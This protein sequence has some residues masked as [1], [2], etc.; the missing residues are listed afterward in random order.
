MCPLGPTPYGNFTLVPRSIW[1]QNWRSVA[2]HDSTCRPIRDSAVHDRLPP[3]TPLRLALRSVACSSALAIACPLVARADDCA[4]LEERASL[5]RLS[6]TRITSVQV[7]TEGPSLPGL[8]QRAAGLHPVSR[9]ETIQRQLLF[10]AGDTVDTILVGETMR[11]LRAQRLFSDAVLTAQYCDAGSNTSAGTALVVRTRDAWTLRPTARLRSSSSLSVGIEERNLLG[12]GRTLAVTTELSTRG[13]GAGVTFIDPWLF[14]RD[15]SGTFRAAKLAGAHVFRAG[16]R[17]HEYS[18]F[19]SWRAEGNFARNSYGDTIA[20]ERSLHTVAAMLLVGRRIGAPSSS[21]VTLLLAGAEFDSASA[22]SP[23]RRMRRDSAAVMP[24]VRSFLGLDLGLMRRTALYDTASWIV[25]GRGFL[26]VPLGWEGEAV[27]GSGYERDARSPA[28]KL[29]TWLGRIW[30]PQRGSIFTLDAW[31]SGYAGRGVDANDIAR[32]SA[33]WYD[34]AWGGMW[35]ARF[36]A[37]RMFEVDPDR[38]SLSLMMLTDY[39][40]PVVRPFA[41]RAGRTVA[42]S[43]ERSAHLFQVGAASVFD[44]GAFAGASYR[45]GVDGARDRQLR[46]GVVGARFRLLSANGAVSSVRLDVGYP[47][48]LNRSLRRKP[49]A[50]LTFGNLFDVVRQRDGRRQF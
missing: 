40:A 1:R 20:T 2:A 45:W 3:P 44:A 31:L 32:L 47:V 41:L 17:N 35:G 5:A 23:T 24:H 8:A 13:N 27:V 48:M 6:G 49:F 30:L 29:D 42:G 19:D 37:E 9:P 16:L 43:I 22:I 46:A 12:T 14:G 28:F 10:A 33:G 11:R 36:T 18:V 34:Q 38:R 4:L 26:D 25:P 15:V 39:T 21:G 7:V 50:V